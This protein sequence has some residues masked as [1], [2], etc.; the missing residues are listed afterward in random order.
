MK[1]YTYPSNDGE[2]LLNAIVN[3]G[4]DFPKKEIAAVSKIISD[5]KKRGDQ[6]V[7][8]YTRRFDAPEMTSDEIM[9][10]L[11]NLNKNKEA[12]EKMKSVLQLADLVKFA[13]SHPTPLENDISLNHV[14]DFVNET[15]MIPVPKPEGDEAGENQ[16]KKEA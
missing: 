9:E 14:V 10:N 1:I 5:V 11:Y 8:E 7:V 12:N 13:K 16:S 4:G 2:A 3:R 15:K 6:A